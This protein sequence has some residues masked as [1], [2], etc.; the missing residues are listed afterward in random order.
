[1]MSY[2]NNTSSEMGCVSY[3]DMKRIAGDREMWLQRPWLLSI[4]PFRF[5]PLFLYS[6]GTRTEEATLDIISE[7]LESPNSLPPP[8]ATALFHQSTSVPIACLTLPLTLTLKV[9]LVARIACLTLPLTLPLTLT[10][11]VGLVA[12]IAC[13]TLPLTLTLKVGLVARIACLTLPS[14]SHFEGGSC[15]KNSVPDSPSDSDFEDPPRWRSCLTRLSC[16]ARLLRT[17]RSSYGLLGASGCGKTTLLSCIVGRRRLNTGEIHVL[18][19][20]PGTKGSGVPGKRVG[21]MPQTGGRF[22]ILPPAKVG[23]S[24]KC[25]AHLFL[26]EKTWK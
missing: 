17:G 7:G 19:G 23:M 15:C 8:P 25:Q 18:G 9:G 12:R 1:M 11:K 5:P 3:T 4:S 20:K 22:P 16:L 13:L 10:L 24:S 26:A 21:Y 14:D 2:L 6:R